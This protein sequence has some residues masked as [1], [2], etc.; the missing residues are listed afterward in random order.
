MTKRRIADIN[1][2]KRSTRGAGLWPSEPGYVAAMR[3]QSKEM[4]DALLEVLTIFEEATPDI[5]VEALQ[6]T[7]RLAEYYTPK[8]TRAL[9][10]SSYLEVTSFRG[11]PRVELGFARGGNPPYAMYVHEILDYKH[12]SPTGAKFLERA[13]KEDMT[14][15]YQRL[16][17]GYKDL[18][19]GGA[20]G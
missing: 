6:P 14:G 2:G 20:N 17:E 7:R 12:A 11:K 5:M 3:E 13:L 10:E 18:M 15:I 1:I 8:D 4:T 9:V 19:G 16:A